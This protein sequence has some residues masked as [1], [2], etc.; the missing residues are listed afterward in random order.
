MIVQAVL[1]CGKMS[2]DPERQNRS[3]RG[4]VGRGKG[5][6]LS[7]VCHGLLVACSSSLGISSHSPSCQ[8]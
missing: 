7:L 1:A 2:Q 6:F 4:M 8:H 3:E 5:V